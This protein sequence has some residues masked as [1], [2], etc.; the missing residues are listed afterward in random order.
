VRFNMAAK[1]GDALY[2][3]GIAVAGLALLSWGVAPLIIAFVSGPD[4]GGTFIVWGL[5]ALPAA[6]LSY[7]V[8]L[9]CRNI[10]SKVAT[11]D[12]ARDE[13]VVSRTGNSTDDA[14]VSRTSRR[15]EK[16]AFRH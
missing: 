1:F 6:A 15:R 12:S 2:W 14:V 13:S 16:R 8:G 7:S 11:R 4:V 9:A 10:F 5:I 3:T